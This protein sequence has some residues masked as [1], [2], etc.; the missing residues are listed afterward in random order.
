VVVFERSVHTQSTQVVLEK[1]KIRGKL[2][3]GRNRSSALDRPI[4][5]LER[6]V[7]ISSLRESV[8]TLRHSGSLAGRRREALKIKREIAP[9]VMTRSAALRWRPITFL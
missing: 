9:G 6:T 4:V 2:N 8:H 5:F 1:L 3:R 7:R